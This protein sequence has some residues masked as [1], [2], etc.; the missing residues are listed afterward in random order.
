MITNKNLQLLRAFLKY[1][2]YVTAKRLAT[3]NAVSERSIR[4]Y[5]SEIS[6]LNLALIHSTNLGYLANKENIILFLADYDK[7]TSQLTPDERV[8]FII[9]SFYLTNKKLDET[10][11]IS[12]LSEQLFISEESIKK[13]LV[14]IRKQIKDFDLTLSTRGD[15]IKIEGL[16]KNKRRLFS[17][18]LNDEFSKAFFNI[19]SIKN[20]FPLFDVDKLLKII[21]DC[22]S[23]YSY[24]INEYTLL[25]LLIDILIS[26]DRIKNSHEIIYLAD[27]NFHFG[28]REKLLSLDIINNI[29]S[30]FDVSFNDNERLQFETTLS[31]CLLPTLH[32]INLDN[33][34]NS[35]LIK[36]LL[37]E[38]KKYNFIDSDHQDFILKFSLHIKNLLIRAKNSQFARN[39]ITQNIK[40][41]CPLIF[42]CAVDI[43]RIINEVENLII[44]EDEIGYIALHLGSMII[45]QNSYKVRCLLHT[46]DYHNSSNTII[47]KL[48][49]VFNDN[50]LIN[51]YSTSLDSLEPNNEYDLIISTVAI[52][53]VTN[54][55][56]VIITPFLLDRDIIKLQYKIDRILQ[57]KKKQKV[58][59]NLLRISN[60]SLFFILDQQ[61]DC[62]SSVEMLSNKMIDLGYVDNRFI[63]SVMMRE[64]EYST[65]FG[66][67]AVPHAIVMNAYKTGLSILINNE[68]VNW[69]EGFVNLVLLFS[70]SKDDTA[71]FYDVF[72]NLIILLLEP[73][74]LKR[75]LTAQNYHDFISIMSDIL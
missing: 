57:K 30:E 36:R 69:D 16:E 45:L 22:C 35:E 59:N 4:K 31:N 3:D 6:Q 68:G 10:I 40:N 65:R 23:S 46:P 63:Q 55:D 49:T 60:P 53:I 61:I 13:D 5:I 25:S 71:L 17:T 21:S 37:A 27:K 70:I 51:V 42:Y 14:I 11:Y 26:I 58:I 29:E 54:A 7:K 38:I 2:G 72:D 47:Q 50:L 15:E 74:N 9:K 73:E 75:I 33:T 32:T 56:I 12:K 48:R 67:I 34:S 41:S 18:I 39:P 43:A 44:S 66:K 19:K 62:N 20:M 8:M 24:N 52:N 1:D 28:E 64:K